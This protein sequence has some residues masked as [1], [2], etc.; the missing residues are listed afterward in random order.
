MAA[1]RERPVAEA[2]HRFSSADRNCQWPWPS[3]IRRPSAAPSP[4][5]R[6]PVVSLVGAAVRARLPGDR[7]RTALPYLWWTVLGSTGIRRRPC[8][9]ASSCWRVARSAWPSSASGLL[10]PKQPA[11]VRAGIF[12]ACRRLPGRPAADPLGELW[13]EYWVYANRWFGPSGVTVGLRCGGRSAVAPARR[14]ESTCSSGPDVEKYPGPAG[15]A[16]AGSRATAY[17]RLQGQRVRRGTILGILL[18]AGSGIYTMMTT[19]SCAAAA[20]QLVAEHPVHRQVTVV[21]P[22]ATPPR[23]SRNCRVRQGTSPDR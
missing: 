21:E 12:V 16:R 11:G 13:L 22:R 18:L 6:M 10:G 8:C 3:R 14:L 15:E 5:D 19:A 23:C 7:V 1:R 20:R 4:L 9:S 17:K 2:L